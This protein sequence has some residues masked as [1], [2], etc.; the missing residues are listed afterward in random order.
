MG[1]GAQHNE[2]EHC[3]RPLI[4]PPMAQSVK[5]ASSRRTSPAGQ[6]FQP[7]HVVPVGCTLR[8]HLS[9]HN[10]RVDQDLALVSIQK[11]ETGAYT[12]CATNSKHALRLM[13][14]ITYY[15]DR[16]Q[17][18]YLFWSHFGCWGLPGPLQKLLM[19]T[20]PLG[21]RT[22]ALAHVRGLRMQQR[23]M[24]HAEKGARQKR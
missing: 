15:I 11:N 8:Q 3:G 10:K 20:D 5:T 13:R 1:M 17:S 14:S 22:P 19:K 12:L 7:R 6:L 16:E 21:Q 18:A 2:G 24:E 4:A 9:F 23:S